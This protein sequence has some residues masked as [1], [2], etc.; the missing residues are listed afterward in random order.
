[1]LRDV[2]KW[3]ELISEYGRLRSLT[4]HTP[5]SRGQRFNELIVELLRCWGIESTASVRTTGEVDVVFAHSGVRF[6]L[7]AKWQKAKADT[8]NIAKLQKRVR[9]RIAGTCGIFLSMSGYSAEALA[10]IADGE[11]LEVLLLDVSHWE[12]MLAGLVPPEELLRLVHDR[13]AFFGQPYT[14]LADLLALKTDPPS[15]AF[16]LPDGVQEDVLRTGVDGAAAE[17]VLSG[18]DS[19]QLGIACR[20]DSH[21][22]VTTAQAILDV[23]LKRRSVTVAVPV[24]DCHRNPVPLDDGSVLYAR[25]HGVGRFAKGEVSVVGG[26][27]VGNSSVLVHPDGGAWLFDNGSIGGIS[28]SIARLGDRVGD[29]TRYDVGYQPASAFSSVWISDDSLLTVG[30]PNLVVTSIP[31][32]NTSS[33]AAS[34]SNPMGIVHLGDGVV[35]TAGDGTSVHRTDTNTWSTD[36]L[37]DLGLN[38]S[39]NELALGDNDDVYIAAY[40]PWA[41]SG[42]RFAVVRLSGLGR[43]RGADSG[44]PA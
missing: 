37:V 32:G 44:E 30:N 43:A 10:D 15:V 27:S 41:G 29:E 42:M 34:Q 18:I 1:M 5:Q 7:E 13:A 16:G 8:G 28:P 39:V 23:D 9:Q 38:S 4:G 24:P 25:R 21:L 17:V 20:G 12:A 33:H 31:S 26:G 6:V 35:L 2:A 14:A 3:R 11:R 19:N 40:Q 22:L 36:Q